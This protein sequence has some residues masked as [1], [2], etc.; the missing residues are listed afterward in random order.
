MCSVDSDFTSRQLLLALKAGLVLERGWSDNP[1]VLS[2]PLNLPAEKV[3]TLLSAVEALQRVPNVVAVV[4]GGSYACGLAR[5]GSDIDIGLYYRERSPFS[6]DEVR[7]V[8]ETICGAGSNPIVTGT[9]EWG[10]WVNG[11]AWI[12]TRAGK[13]DFLLG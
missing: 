2:L 4:L 5:P 9:Y 12:Q 11:G 13:V 8:A 7:S 10:P 1:R 3:P 6:V